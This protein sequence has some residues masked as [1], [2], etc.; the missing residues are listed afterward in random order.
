MGPRGGGGGGGVVLRPSGA[1]TTSSKYADGAVRW[2]LAA[3]RLGAWCP[4]PP[5]VENSRRA[6]PICV[7]GDAA[8]GTP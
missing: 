5:A 3:K 7:A 8:I 1:V 2:N 4:T 6:A